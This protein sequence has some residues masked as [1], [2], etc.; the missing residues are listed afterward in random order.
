MV[1][2]TERTALSR[3]SA[4]K[5][6]L[7]RTAA[8]TGPVDLKRLRS[9]VAELDRCGR[10]PGWETRPVRGGANGLIYY[11]R[12]EDDEVAVK[13]CAEDEYDRAGREYD[14]LRV[15][16][17]VDPQL[18]P[19]PL[20]LERHL[21]KRPVVV[22]TWVSGEV[23]TSLPQ[24]DEDWT[25]LLEHYVAL[26]RIHPD[27]VPIHLERTVLNASSFD[28]AKE[29]VRQ[30]LA[31]LPEQGFRD[32]L[33]ELTQRL[34]ASTAPV[35][36]RPPDALCRGDSNL[37]NFV[38]REKAWCSLDWEYGGWGD[39]AFEI[40]EMIAHPAYA[41][42]PTERWPWVVARYSEWTG[43]GG[44]SERIRWYLVALSVWWTVRCARYLYEVPRGLDR[45][46]VARSDGFLAQI[47]RQYDDYHRLSE[48]RLEGQVLP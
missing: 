43:N 1:R 29:L 15:L 19:R 33:E 5:A 4:V 7:E 2:P 12:N 37:T 28:K 18:A 24:T 13:F 17:T 39:P 25:M 32:G 22:Q 42:V 35:W 26:A 9:L 20:L 40:A 14:A 44:A 38:R 45:R 21:C 10:A 47:E 34:F 16:H 48:R 46:L 30:Q 3:T 11:A 36:P 31:R 41:N 6:W 27:R 23:S 8:Y